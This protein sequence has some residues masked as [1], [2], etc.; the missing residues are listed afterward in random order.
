MNKVIILS[1]LAKTVAE[2]TQCS[3]EDA[4]NFVRETFRLAAEH[5]ETDRR[6]EI[7]GLG[8]FIVANES[9]DFAPD[10][11]FAAELNAPF[12][13]FEAIELPDDFESEKAEEKVEAA[14]ETVAEQNEEIA[15]AAEFEEAEDAAPQPDVPQPQ[16]ETQ[17]ETSKPE[18]PEPVVNEVK[19][20]SRGY[21]H[22]IWAAACLLCFALGW[23]ARGFE[24]G[25]APIPAE[26]PLTDT[27]NNLTNLSDST[28]TEPAPEP[29][30]EPVPAP[31]T[32]TITATRFLTTMARQ[33]YGQM[34]YWVYIYEANATKL[35][36]PDRLSAGT[37]V[38]IP[39]LE[40]DLSDP[41][42]IDV[43]KRMAKEIYGR[44]N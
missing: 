24:P 37:V 33:H 42:Q 38:T 27:I 14:E 7:P 20:R 18:K 41:A 15:A 31:I 43:A 9:I 11:D 2:L 8:T 25:T 44:F 32:D 6:V 39:V 22:W 40:F 36:H 13:A 21:I 26:H 35:G 1:E 30:A 23:F 10:S 28:I 29:A 12:A 3:V 4:E 16:E 5:L 19:T 34:E 17:V